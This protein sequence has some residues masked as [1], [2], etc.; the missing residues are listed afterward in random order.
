MDAGM[1]LSHNAGDLAPARGGRYFF[2]GEPAKGRAAVYTNTSDW[3]YERFDLR[4]KTPAVETEVTVFREV[5]YACSGS[6]SLR[7]KRAKGKERENVEI[8]D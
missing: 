1:L 6:G 5:I 3:I 7:V 2:A 4:S 8:S